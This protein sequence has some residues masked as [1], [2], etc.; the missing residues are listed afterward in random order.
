[1]SPRQTF[2]YW[3]WRQ[4]RHFSS[5]G[6]T[7]A[8][9]SSLINELKTCREHILHQLA[10]CHLYSWLLWWHRLYLTVSTASCP[11]LRSHGRSEIEPN[12]GMSQEKHWWT[13]FHLSA[14][15]RKLVLTFPWRVIGYSAHTELLSV[16][17]MGGRFVL[18]L[19][20]PWN[21]SKDVTENLIWR[22]VLYK[23]FHLAAI[24]KTP[25]QSEPQKMSLFFQ[26]FPY[27]G[28]FV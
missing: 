12:K 5:C 22:P 9:V 15:Q 7:L 19:N 2:V 18:L 11:W 13:Q 27:K 28:G 3:L 16:C 6:L 17:W 25:K 21:V 10:L 20:H 14:H 8:Q 24:N 26:R 4:L 1:M 23:R